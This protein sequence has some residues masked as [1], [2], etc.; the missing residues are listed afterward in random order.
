MNKHKAPTIGRVGMFVYGCYHDGICVYIGTTDSY[1][2]TERNMNHN[3][4]RDSELGRFILAGNPVEVRN[5]GWYLCIEEAR[6]QARNLKHELQ[7]RYNVY[8]TCRNKRVPLTHGPATIFHG[9]DL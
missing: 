3:P 8:G 9:L 6:Q 7:P 1:I 2:R 4:R 5:L